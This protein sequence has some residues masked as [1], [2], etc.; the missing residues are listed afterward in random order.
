VQET[1][2]KSFELQ[3]NLAYANHD[4]VELTGDLYLPAGAGPFP[5][6]VNVH[7]GYWRRGSRDTFQH[8]G[9]YLAERGI[10]GYTISYRLTKPGKS[11]FPGVVN[12]V[13]AAV[14]FMRG[15]A[16]DYRLNPDRFALWGNSAG[17]HLASMV[18]LAGDGPLFKNAYPD[19]PHASVSTKVKVLIGTY[20]IYDLLAQWKHSLIQN[21]SDNLVQSML[22]ASPQ[23]NRKLYFD[24]SPIS[25]ATFD[26]NKT[27]VYL[28]WGTEDDTVDYKTQ[29]FE[30]LTALKQA[31]FQ[32]RPCIV[33]GAGHY[34]L[35]DPID[36][37]GSQSGFVAPRL[38]RFL[39]ERL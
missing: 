4:G 34:W 38:M 16:K 17:A 26:N 12:D 3:K 10:A 7:G 2:K 13:R 31:E 28:I 24:A 35:S 32:V 27:A 11:T 33:E 18:A 20:G 9:P 1:T 19:D 8:W 22:G 14:Q 37:P 39:A 36:E 15:N 5:L 30:F 25:Y 6:I 21:P 29:S 23:Q